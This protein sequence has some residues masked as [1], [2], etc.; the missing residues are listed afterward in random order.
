MAP[1]ARGGYGLAVQ[2][3]AEG[4]GAML[5][6]TMLVLISLLAYLAPPAAAQTACASTGARFKFGATSFPYRLIQFGVAR[7]ADRCCILAQEPLRR[8]RATPA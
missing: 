6:A 2:A 8:C 5:R 3:S 4:K 1:T 7:D